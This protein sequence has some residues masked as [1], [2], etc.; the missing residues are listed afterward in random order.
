MASWFQLLN[1]PRTE[2]A[3]T[4]GAQTLNT[5]AP[6][7]TSVAPGG[8]C[9]NVVKLIPKPLASVGTAAVM[10]AVLMYALLL[11]SVNWIQ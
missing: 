3:A 8:A 4:S 9:S 6:P 11:P 2:A 5:A 1:A 7:F 10:P